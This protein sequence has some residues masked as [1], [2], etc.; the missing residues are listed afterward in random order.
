[1]TAQT[2]LVLGKYGH[3]DSELFG[4]LFDDKSVKVWRAAWAI[5]ATFG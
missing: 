5:M 2:T 4:R 1:M 3:R